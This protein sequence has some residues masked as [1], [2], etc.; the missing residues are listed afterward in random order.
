MILLN[1]GP[2][3]IRKVGRDSGRGEL[4]G[5]VV[6]GFGSIGLRGRWLGGESE[7]GWCRVIQRGRG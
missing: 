4:G 1:G 6:A 7:Y 5:R 3:K 2:V